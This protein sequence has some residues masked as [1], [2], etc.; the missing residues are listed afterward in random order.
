MLEKNPQGLEAYRDRC[1]IDTSAGL[2]EKMTPEEQKEILEWALNEFV[3][4]N[5][6]SLLGNILKRPRFYW[7]LAHDMAFF[8]HPGYL[9]GYL[10]DYLSGMVE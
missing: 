1:H 3:K 9:F 5:R 2:M 4:I 6:K 10:K 8:R 7:A